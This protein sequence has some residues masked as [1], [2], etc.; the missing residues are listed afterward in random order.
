M[1]HL[2]SII[3]VTFNNK[4]YL[5]LCIESIERQIFPHEIII[6]DNQ[7]QDGT[8]DLIRT[9]FP[10]I[11]FIKNNSNKGYGAANNLGVLHAKGEF[12]VILNPDTIVDQNWLSELINPL[13]K[14]EKIITTPKILVY[15]GSSINT[16]GNINHFTGLSFINGFTKNPLEMDNLDKFIGIS[17]AC[18]AL[19]RQDF[20][21]LGGFD[22]AFF[23]YQED[24]ELSWRAHSQG[25]SIVYV[26]SSLIRHDYSLNLSPEK[27][28]QLEKGRYMI[29]RKY[30]T[31][32]EILRF[33]PSL[34]LTEILTTCYS[35]K[36]GYKGIY[37]KM[38][39]FIDGNKA[40][41]Q[42]I[43]VNKKNLLP[44][45]SSNIPIDQL[46]HSKLHIAI[47]K[48]SN[49]IFKLNYGG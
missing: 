40:N 15:D 35:C 6:V 10:D 16:C 7:S 39:A 5:R 30:Y 37:F 2:A 1:E 46:C 38:K 19:K 49:A 8:F 17:G 28:Y 41:I 44:F 48:V 4:K 25:Y 9:N 47:K 33:L 34:I 31:R 20:L 11:D 12:I 14:N 24:T 21:N 29:L 43:S 18:F 36:Y 13:Q 45:L 22:E 27:I 26:P 32:K 23:L 3:I 42:K